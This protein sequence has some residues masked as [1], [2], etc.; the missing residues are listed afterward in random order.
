[1]P[2]GT[3]SVEEAA[4]LARTRDAY[5]FR[6]SSDK[7]ISVWRSEGTNDWAVI[8]E[9][10]PAFAPSCLNRIVFVK[11]T[12]GFPRILNAVARFVSQ[13]STVG[14]A[15]MNERTTAFAAELAQAG[16]ARACPIGQMQRPP[17]S[18][19][20]DG[21]PNLAPLVRWTDIG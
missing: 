16:I 17:L 18:W 11:P 1:L 13:V 12:D 14:L 21:Q 10:D 20:H 6:A 15:P 9:D 5:V 19:Y 3:L 7:R 8:Y 2:R 4:V